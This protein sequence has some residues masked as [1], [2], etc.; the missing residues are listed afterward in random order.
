MSFKKCEPDVCG[1]KEQSRHQG[2]VVSA[3]I[4]AFDEGA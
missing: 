3:L 2:L 4:E 1:K